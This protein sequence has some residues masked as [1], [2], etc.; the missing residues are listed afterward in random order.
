[1]TG[2]KEP[3]S[4][5]QQIE[6]IKKRGCLVKDD[7]TCIDALNRIGYYR[8]SAYFLPFKKNDNTYASGVEFSRILNIY[9]FDR[10]LRSVILSALEE[11]EIF[12][13]S[14]ISYYHTKKYGSLGYMIPSNYNLKHDHEKFR[15]TYEREISSHSSVAFVEHHIKKYNGKFPLWVLMELFSFGMISKFYNDLATQDRKAIAKGLDVNYKQLSSWLRCCTDLRNIC[16]HYGRL[17]YRVFPAIPSGINGNDYSKRHL[18]SNILVLKKLYPSK[19]K[20]I[21]ELIPKFEEVIIKYKDDINLNC[22][23]FPDNWKAILT[24]E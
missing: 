9:E 10:E 2:V 7:A 23:A 24:E 5:N 11:I 16:A 4:Y 20:W 21:S 8:L 22:I 19:D 12:L 13:R 15:K 6:L 17:Y 3:S 18:W 14:Q 1:M